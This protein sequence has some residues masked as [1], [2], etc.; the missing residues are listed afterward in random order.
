MEGPPHRGDEAG[1]VHTCAAHKLGA[2][3]FRYTRACR[4]IVHTLV[5]A[6]APMTIAAMIDGCPD[7]PSSSAYRNVRNLQGAGVVVEVPHVGAARYELSQGVGAARRHHALC[8]SCGDVAVAPST[9]RVDAAVA[10][11]VDSLREA[12]VLAECHQV[13]FVGTCVRCGPRSGQ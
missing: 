12:G 5:V 4:T 6:D 1:D 8:R 11:A 2:T 13:A 10:L 3:G 7:L 9:D